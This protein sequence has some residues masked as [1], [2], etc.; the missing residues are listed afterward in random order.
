MVPKIGSLVS[1][2]SSISK[3]DV[4]L[5]LVLGS[6]FGMVVRSGA[7]IGSLYSLSISSLSKVEKMNSRALVFFSSSKKAV[8]TSCYF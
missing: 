6:K 4:Y 5:V 1:S 2:S 3:T 7:R 8:S